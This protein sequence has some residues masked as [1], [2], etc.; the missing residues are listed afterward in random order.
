MIRIRWKKGLQFAAQD[1]NG[2]EIVVDTAISTGGFGQGFSPMDL[3][4]A[5]LA[6]CMSMDIVAILGKKGA[7][8]TEFTVDINGIRADNHPKRYEKITAK[9][10]CKGE[11]K[12]EDFVR[13]F[14]LS[15]DKYCSVAATLRNNPVIEYVIDQRAG[16]DRASDM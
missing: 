11:Y 5:A 13:S 1:E 6:G 4:L 10:A 8:I 12:H 7:R 3:L 16:A 14:E 9:I 2:H 15:R